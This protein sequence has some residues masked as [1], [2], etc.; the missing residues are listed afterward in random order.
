MSNV[1]RLFETQF[2]PSILG[3]FSWSLANDPKFGKAFGALAKV[4]QI[5]CFFHRLFHCIVDKTHLFFCFVFQLFVGFRGRIIQ[6]CRQFLIRYGD[7]TTHLGWKTSEKCYSLKI[8][9]FLVLNTVARVL[10]NFSQLISFLIFLFW[11]IFSMNTGLVKENALLEI[12]GNVRKCVSASVML[13]SMRI[14]YNQKHI[15]TAC[16]KFSLQSFLYFF[17]FS[18]KSAWRS[19]NDVFKPIQLEEWTEVKQKKKRPKSARTHTHTHTNHRKTDLQMIFLLITMLVGCSS[20]NQKGTSKS[21]RFRT[22][23]TT[24]IQQL[25]RNPKADTGFIKNTNPAKLEI[26]I[27]PPPQN[28]RRHCLW[29][30]SSPLDRWIL[31]QLWWP[32]VCGTSSQGAGPW[33]AVFYQCRWLPWISAIWRDIQ[34]FCFLGLY[35]TVQKKMSSSEA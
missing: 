21:N 17:F 24:K 18:R 12:W 11:G 30:Q 22:L 6:L 31:C 35:R 19:W 10:L 4:R 14:Y 32:P 3:P 15:D 25:C 26:T 29:T 9:A 2:W 27:P 1:A 13:L 28:D 33:S 8:I 7:H 5:C 23:S 16:F 34:D 20:A